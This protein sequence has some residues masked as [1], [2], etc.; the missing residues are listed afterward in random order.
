[1]QVAGTISAS[2]AT[3]A[4]QV[5][6]KSQLD[7]VAARPYKVYTALLIQ[8]GTSAPIATVLENTLGGVVTWNYVSVGF[9]Q[10][11]LSSAFT[12][13]K[14]AVFMNTTMPNSQFIGFVN[15]VNSI[16]VRTYD[17]SAVPFTLTDG[18]MPNTS[19]TSIEI[20]V[21]N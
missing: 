20:R 7:A 13:G 15:S 12:L 4:N 18:K 10:G 21:Y 16:G 14:T 9:Y 6:V 17:T 8:T 5:V 1:M 2:P 19:Y 11:S 3:T